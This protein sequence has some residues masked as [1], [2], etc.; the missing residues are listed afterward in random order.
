MQRLPAQED[1]MVGEHD[2]SGSGLELLD[3]VVQPL[4]EDCNENPE[5]KDLPEYRDQ[6]GNEAA[7]QPLIVAQVSRI[8]EPQ[9]GP[10]A[11]S[12]ATCPS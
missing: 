6:R 4:R 8:R 9:E 10:L 1:D 7:C 5:K 11:F 3:R 12:L 2:G